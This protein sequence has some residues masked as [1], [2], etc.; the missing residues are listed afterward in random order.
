[1]MQSGC[2][3]LPSTDASSLSPTKGLLLA[4]GLWTGIALL[5]LKINARQTGDGRNKTFCVF[6]PVVERSGSKGEGAEEF[7]WFKIFFLSLYHWPKNI[8]DNFKPQQIQV[9]MGL[10]KLHRARRILHIK[11]QEEKIFCFS[12]QKFMKSKEAGGWGNGLIWKYLIWSS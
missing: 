4:L 7:H 2:L 6:A 3:W 10:E 1:M 11:M 8:L 5:C 9:S 12:D